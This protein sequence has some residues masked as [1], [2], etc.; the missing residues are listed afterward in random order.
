MLANLIVNKD[1]GDNINIKKENLDNLS[2]NLTIKTIFK[3]YPNLNK[4]KSRTNL[5][6]HINKFLQLS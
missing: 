1:K 5:D 4:I 2:K 3:G 6:Y